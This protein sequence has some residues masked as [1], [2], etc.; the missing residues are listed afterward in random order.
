MRID[1]ASGGAVPVL[2]G[3]E[4][5]ASAV[6]LEAICEPVVEDFAMLPGPH[7]TPP[8]M[9]RLRDLLDERLAEDSMAG[10]VV[11]HGTDTLEETAAF[12]DVTLASQK[13][14]VMTGSL[15]NSSETSW[16]GPANLLAAAKVAVDPDAAGRGVMV[17]LAQ[18]VH[19]AQEVR[20]SD[21][22]AVETFVSPRSGPVG[23]VDQDGVIW[24][25]ETAPRPRVSI[26]S[27]TAE[28][29]IIPAYTGAAGWMIDAAIAQG[30]KGMVLE[31]TGRGNVPPTMV[32]AVREALRQGVVVVVASRCWKGRVLPT[33]AYPG[34][35][36]DLAKLGVLFAHR[37]PAQQ[38][39]LVMIAHLS[40]GSSLAEL[41]AALR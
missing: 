28:V 40:A 15:R 33:Y 6:G 29:A 30:V 36:G 21:T 23:L 18:S 11:T 39:R 16:D 12:L 41:Q 4:I 9:L 24:V 34:S 20:K 13:P 35:G 27:V 14:V 32:D 10:A 2:S 7:V 38:A 26:S 37:L 19:A 1:A 5:L 31:G 22:H 17:A 8:V 3:A 25:G